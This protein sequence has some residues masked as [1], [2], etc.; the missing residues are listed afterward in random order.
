MLAPGEM[1]F[2]GMGAVDCVTVYKYIRCYAVAPLKAVCIAL[3]SGRF[4]FGVN[5]NGGQGGETLDGDPNIQSPV[6]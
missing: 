5:Q 2:E 1:C 4:S 3:S 6:E